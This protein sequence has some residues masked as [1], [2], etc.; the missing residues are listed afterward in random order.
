[1]RLY[2]YIGLS[3]VKNEYKYW[4][5]RLSIPYLKKITLASLAGFNF[6]FGKYHHALA[7]L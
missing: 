2:R 5:G 6:V 4:N 1:M 7:Q 3:V